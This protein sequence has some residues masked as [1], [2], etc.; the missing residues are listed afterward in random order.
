MFAFWSGEIR[1]CRTGGDKDLVLLT[2]NLADCERHTRVRHVGD[3]VD[4]IDVVPLVGNLR[5]DIRFVLV[6]A[7][8]HLNFHIRMIFHEIRCRHPG[9]NH[10]SDAGRIR[11]E[12]RHIGEHADLDVHLLCGGGAA[13]QNDAK[14]RQTHQSFH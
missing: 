8:D 11:I 14:G 13:G 2:G 3:H 5:A 1:T 9:S 10:G 12:A 7:A 4:V 6:V